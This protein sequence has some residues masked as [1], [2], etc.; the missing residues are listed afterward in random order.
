M[1]M[2]YKKS[3]KIAVLAV[4]LT[5]IY[6]GC[7]FGAVSQEEAAQLGKNLTPF[8]AEIAGNKDGSIPPYTGGLTKAPATYVAGSGWRPDPFA[9]EKPLFSITGQNAA[10]YANKLSVGTMAL[11]KKFP[12]FRL[13]VYKTHRTVAYPDYVL[14][15]TVKNAVTAKLGA[16]KKGVENLVQGGIPFPIPKNGDEIILNHNMRYMGSSWLT[17]AVS[18]VCQEDGNFYNTA[19]PLMIWNEFPNYYEDKEA[20]E[21]NNKEYLYWKIRWIFEGPV[22]KAGEGGQGIHHIIGDQTVGPTH[23]LYLP[24]Q[25][26]VKLAPEVSFDTPDTDGAGTW[27]YDECWLFNGEM[28]RYNYKLIGKKELY[29]PYN[30]Y[31]LVYYTGDL[32]QMFKPGSYINPDLIRW[33]LHRVWVVEIALKPGKRHIYPKRTFYIDED[34]WAII[35]ADVYDAHGNIYKSSYHELVQCYDMMAPITY[36]YMHFNLINGVSSRANYMRLG[37]GY[38]KPIPPQ[39]ARWWSPDALAG[40]GL[41]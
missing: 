27:T 13:D 21:R 22:R 1:T 32:K 37:M 29:I 23:H 40:K 5:L 17:R 35:A 18:T 36:S 41:R 19:E 33:E 12:G 15:A 28:S 30:T 4:F 8:G 31:R 34:S 20:R 39:T 24:G 38:L 25:R 16:N 11:L 10:Q 6:A 3:M 7:V 2:L 14:D 26:R 9:S